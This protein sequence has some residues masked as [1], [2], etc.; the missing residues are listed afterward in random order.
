MSKFLSAVC[1]VLIVSATCANAQDRVV[2]ESMPLEVLLE[3]FF[4]GENEEEDDALLWEAIRKR[5]YADISP[6]VRF[7]ESN[8]W[9]RRRMWAVP[10]LFRGSEKDR[11]IARNAVLRLADDTNA[12]VASITLSCIGDSLKMGRNLVNPQ[13]ASAIGIKALLGKRARLHSVALRLLSLVPTRTCISFIRK[14]AYG[15]RWKPAIREQALSY[16]KDLGTKPAH[17]AK[18]ATTRRRAVHAVQRRPYG[19]DYLMEN[20]DVGL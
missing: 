15:T 4:D 19:T 6:F 18:G 9:W 7:S 13:Q 14:V 5:A 11:R 1:L 12:P 16:L 17:S 20:L 10:F 8:T 2:P 3:Q